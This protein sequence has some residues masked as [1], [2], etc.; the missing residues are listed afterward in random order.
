MFVC[1]IW[2][3]TSRKLNSLNARTQQRTTRTEHDR[4]TEW[5]NASN[6][7][8]RRRRTHFTCGL[9]PHPRSSFIIIIFLLVLSLFATLYYKQ[10]AAAVVVVV[11]LSCTS[12][13]P[14]PLPLDHRHY[15]LLP[16]NIK[17]LIRRRCRSR[18]RKG[19]TCLFFFLLHCLF[20]LFD[21]WPVL[22]RYT[23]DG[24]AVFATAAATARFRRLGLPPP[25][26]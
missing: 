5:T 8:R 12:P 11:V 20:I 25:S 14:P 21:I 23:R 15:F 7:R 3:R 24:A 19:I 10:A 17:C 18:T 16:N 13:P 1:M 22:Q 2:V 26:A 6:G 9:S 4:T